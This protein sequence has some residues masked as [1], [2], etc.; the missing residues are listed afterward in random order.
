MLPRVEY[1][2][3]FSSQVSYTHTSVHGLLHA[4]RLVR[5]HGPTHPL[6][7]QKRARTVH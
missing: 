6:A 5:T 3:L 4:V 1:M 2:I 7:A